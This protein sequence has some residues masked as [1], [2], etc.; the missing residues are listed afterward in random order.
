MAKDLA[1]I[2]LKLTAENEVLIKKLEASEK[3]IGKFTKRSGGKLKKLGGAFKTLGKSLSIGAGAAGIALTALTVKTMKAT[4]AL[5]KTSDKL[6]VMPEKLQAMQRAAQLTGVSVETANMALQRMV[7]RVQE[8]SLG[9]GEAK[10]A[11]ADLGLE[12][13][14]LAQLPVDQQFKRIADAMGG[15][16]SEGEKVRLAM[17]LFDSEGVALVN[18]LALGSKGLT[19]IE[20]DMAALGLTLN[21]VEIAKVEQANDAFLIARENVRS[22][23]QAFVVKLAPAIKLLSDKFSDFA[24]EQGGFGAIA[25]IVF[26][27][28]LGFAKFLIVRFNEMKIA[29]RQ[30]VNDAIKHTTSLMKFLFKISKPIQAFIDKISGAGGNVDLLKQKIERM[31]NRKSSLIGVLGEDSK[32]ITDLNARLE[33]TKAKL[34]LIKQGQAEPSEMAALIQSLEDMGVKANAALQNAIMSPISDE[35][36]QKLIDDTNAKM[37]AVAQQIAEKATAASTATGT[38]TTEETP[39]GEE[40][41]E[42]QLTLLETLQAN[43]FSI[44]EYWKNQ[45]KELDAAFQQESLD[46]ASRHQDEMSKLTDQGAKDKL[47][48]KHLSQKQELK[49]TQGEQKRE[50][51]AT[52]TFFKSGLSDLAKNSRAAFSIQKAMDISQAV[53]NTYSAAMGA[54]KSLAPIPYVGPALGAAAAAAAIGFGAKQVQ[55]IK[56]RKFSKG[57]GVS[58]GGAPST[59]SASAPSAPPEPELVAPDVDFDEAATPFRQEVTVTAADPFTP[60]VIRDFIEKLREEDIA[61]NYDV[62]FVG[63]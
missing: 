9:T 29:F 16:T 13:K 6:G 8:A 31:E 15:V 22:F 5:G 2:N 21:R 19:D 47:K 27:K 44:K 12:A 60:S 42:N 33:E 4:D 51:A 40:P 30:F 24:K 18:T 23:A 48:K 3:R 37:E 46:M 38:A 41:A 28:L 34:E 45:D 32:Q 1:K 53:T 59:P 25:D 26:Q 63:G 61:V 55:A 57:G 14:E 62:N 50:R 39:D 11:I 35:S 20:K 7:R 58:A 17:K 52:A 56:A 43:K 54:Y 49:N 10:A 36:I